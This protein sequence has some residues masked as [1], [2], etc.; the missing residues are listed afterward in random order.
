ML[1]ANIYPENKRIKIV[2]SGLGSCQ[3]LRNLSAIQDG[4]LGEL[5]TSTNALNNH[6][7][8]VL[9]DEVRDMYQGNIY[10]IGNAYIRPRHIMHL[11]DQMLQMGGLI[12][13]KEV[14]HTFT[15]RSGFITTV[16]PD[17]VAF[18]QDTQKFALLSHTASAG[19]RFFIADK[20]A[21]Y[22]ASEAGSKAIRGGIANILETIG[23]ADDAL[24][25]KL[26][27]PGRKA[28]YH[29]DKML[30]GKWKTSFINAVSN[31]DLTAL[32]GIVNPKS[33]GIY[34]TDVVDALDIELQNAIKNNI[35]TSVKQFK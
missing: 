20:I 1:D 22:G 7:V 3:N 31:P 16:T 23:K 8:G 29:F 6:A 13:V 11:Q 18:A 15:P 25:R 2:K 12:E 17:C 21:R 27:I 33:L 28:Q 34:G 24:N 10:L 35:Y 14:T 26:G 4:N 9:H 32:Q 19:A 30:R 5:F